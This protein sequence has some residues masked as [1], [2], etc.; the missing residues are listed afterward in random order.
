MVRSSVRTPPDDPTVAPPPAP[1][2]RPHVLAVVLL[3]VVGAVTV[4]V[5]A[6][7]L[8]WATFD[9]LRD[10][11]ANRL[12]VVGVAIAIGVVGVFLLFWAANRAVGWLP[13]HYRE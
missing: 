1:P 6:F 3:R 13:D 2:G 11:D 10:E 8:L 9:F 7:A 12:L 4:P 5:A